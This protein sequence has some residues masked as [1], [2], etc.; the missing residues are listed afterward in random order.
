MEK[1]KKGRR[2]SGKNGKREYANPISSREDILQAL[3]SS[4]QNRGRLAEQLKLTTA[5]DQEA[6]RRRLRAMVRDGQL[7]INRREQYMPLEQSDLIKGR[8][9]AHRDGFGFLVP[10]EGGDD[11]FLSP[12]QMR[13][14]LHGDRAVV[15]ISNTDE[16]G[17]LE[18]AIVEVIELSLIHI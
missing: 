17:R 4:P 13:Q 5:E 6:L 10:D 15:R 7:V 14:V 1:S 16:R 8:V 3:K 12:R 11:L 18:G 2:R 9:S